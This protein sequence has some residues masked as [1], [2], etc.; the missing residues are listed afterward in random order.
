MPLDALAAPAQ[1]DERARR[2]RGGAVVSWLVCGVEA[3]GQRF[4]VRHRCGDL[5]DHVGD[6]NRGAV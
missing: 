4:E 3:D 2:D 5:A 1:G 6:L